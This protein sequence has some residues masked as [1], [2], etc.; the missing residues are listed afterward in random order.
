MKTNKWSLTQVGLSFSIILLF[1]NSVQAETTNCTPITSLPYTITTQGVYC[2]TGH[3]ATTLATGNIITIMTNNVILD[4]NG[5]KLGGQGAGLGTQATGIYASQRQNITIK[6]GTVRGFFKAIVLSD[7]SP[8]TLSQG[9]LIEDIR[10]DMN[11]YE[12][13]EVSGRGVVVRNNNVVDTGGSTAGFVNA[14][15]IVVQGP[16]AKVMGN[17]VFETAET[18]GGSSVGVKVNEGPGSVVEE[19]RIGNEAMGSGTS[20]GVEVNSSSDVVVVNNRIA[21]VKIG[22]SYVGG[23]T[24]GYRDNILLGVTTPYNGGTEIVNGSCGHACPPGQVCAGGSCVLSCQSGL[25]NCSDVCRDLQTDRS[26]CGNCSQ[27]CLSGYI[28]VAGSCLLSCQSGLTSCGGVCRNLQ[29]DS[30][31]CG[32]CGTVCT[33]QRIC[34]GG[35]CVCPTGLTSCSGS[36]VDTHYHS[37]NCGGCGVVCPVGKACLNSVCQ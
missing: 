37:Q 8:Y 34:S 18:G 32:T 28:C 33:S 25:T 26:N 13:M 31:N 4:L 20:T 19:N 5:F 9:H 7:S 16:G 23:S 21:K 2:F 15:G 11:T 1:C 3:L 12:G 35:A 36:C 14:Y 6:N 10:A 27:T 30:S 24:G 17:N 29:Y 22:V